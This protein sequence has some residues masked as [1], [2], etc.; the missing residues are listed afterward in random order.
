MFPHYPPLLLNRASPLLR[1]PVLSALR[2]RHQGALLEDHLRSPPPHPLVV[3]GRV[4]LVE[5][6]V[7][8]IRATPGRP[9]DPR[10]PLLPRPYL[11]SS[12]DTGSH[13]ISEGGSVEPLKDMCLPDTIETPA[14]PA[15]I[16]PA[17]T[18]KITSVDEISVYSDFF[19]LTSF[20]KTGVVTFSRL[21]DSCTCT[22]CRDS[23][24]RQLN[25]TTGKA[26]QE[27]KGTQITLEK[28]HDSQG[29]SSTGL[30]VK[31]SESHT[32]H[33]DIPTLRSMIG[34][35]A[36]PWSRRSPFLRQTWDASTISQTDIRFTYN[37]LDTSLLPLLKRL[38]SFG[39]VVISDVPTNPTGNVECKLR[40]VMGKIGELRNTFYGETWNVKSMKQSKNVAYTS[41]DLGLHMDLLYF[42]SP[43]RFQALH[44]L[45]NRVQGGMSYFVDSFKVAEDLPRP[46]F[47]ALQQTYI[48][49]RYD[50]DGH[51]LHHSH[52]VIS[53]DFDLANPHSAVNWSPPFRGPTPALTPAAERP[54]LPALAI[55]ASL[56]HQ[57]FNDI[58][59]FEARLGQPEYRYSFLMEEGDLVIFDNRRVLHARTSFSER[60]EKGGLQG[61]EIPGNEARNVANGEPTR[62]LKGCYLD[63]EAVWDKL[64][65]LS[66][67]TMQAMPGGN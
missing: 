42:A 64:S 56:E 60:A 19:T 61:T 15:D 36:T 20:G 67:D 48:P 34:T 31:W 12:F 30:L 35:D 11:A 59:E 33:F 47:T 37:N 17:A 55:A 1:R 45:R 2:R 5:Q 16:V 40:E 27:A 44:C 28:R 23:S 8:A 54:S 38:Q 63:G 10:V 9:V 4:P 14:T 32:C 39:L 46:L 41:L 65:V 21:R 24:T 13:D 25:T 53:R 66:N 62:W 29:S 26:V 50:N 58:A 22:A 43:P 18:F 49:Y 57:M 3:D 6:D 51:Y 7:T 52:P